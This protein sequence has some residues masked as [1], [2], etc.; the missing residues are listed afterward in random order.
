MCIF[1]EATEVTKTPEKRPRGRPKG[2]TKKTTPKVKFSR[3]NKT[4]HHMRFYL[5]RQNTEN[6]M[7][8]KWLGTVWMV[9]YIRWLYCYELSIFKARISR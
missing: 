4:D 3:V 5:E 6:W 8:V 7:S 2:T 9:M 1:Q